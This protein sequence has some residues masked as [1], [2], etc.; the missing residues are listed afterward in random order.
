MRGSS[1]S[2]ATT[3]SM[4]HQTSGSAGSEI[5]SP[6]IAVNPHSTTQKWIWSWALAA[7][8]SELTWIS[9]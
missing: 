6:R 5:I 1:A 3:S 2:A 4:R 7:G 8:E 9:G